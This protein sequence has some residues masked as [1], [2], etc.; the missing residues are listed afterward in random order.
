MKTGFD[1]MRT[2]NFILDKNSKS[3]GSRF[4]DPKWAKVQNTMTVMATGKG[5]NQ[6][7]GN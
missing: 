5:L 6:E 3:K 1:E 2:E 7:G 4:G